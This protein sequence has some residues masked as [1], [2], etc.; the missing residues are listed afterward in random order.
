MTEAA[1]R[2]GRACRVGLCTTAVCAF[3]EFTDSRMSTAGK[4]AAM[5]VA[6][7]DRLLSGIGV[8]FSWEFIFPQ[9]RSFLD[10]RG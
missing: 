5:K 10:M 2:I 3:A 7:F 1:E 8:I 9:G 6:I 4:S